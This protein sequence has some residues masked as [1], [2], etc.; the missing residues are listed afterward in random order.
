MTPAQAPVRFSLE[1]GVRW[2]PE[3]F[4]AE[5]RKAEHPSSFVNLLLQ[6]LGVAIRKNFEMSEHS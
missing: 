1:F 5:A 6:N 4:V 3:E 2:S